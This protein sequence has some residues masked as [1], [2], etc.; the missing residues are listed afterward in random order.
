MATQAHPEFKSRPDRPHPLFAAFVR[1]GEDG[2]TAGR[3]RL[4]IN[5]DEPAAP[6]LADVEPTSASSV[7]DL[8]DAGFLKITEDTVEGPGDESFTR[9]TVRHFGAVVVVAVDGENNAWR[10]ARQFRTAV[11]GDILEVVAGKRDVDGEAPAVT[12]ARG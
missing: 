6:D 4:P 12:A 10:M 3:P 9:V 1:A 2:P 7:G 8:I 5:D 11:G